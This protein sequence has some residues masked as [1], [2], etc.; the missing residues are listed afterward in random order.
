[1]PRRVVPVAVL[2]AI[3]VAL[4]GIVPTTS[5][6]C[7]GATRTSVHGVWTYAQ[8]PD[9]CTGAY[10]DRRGVTMWSL[11]HDGRRFIASG[12]T[13]GAITDVA[14]PAAF[15]SVDGRAWT[16]RLLPFDA[17]LFDAPDT[18]L[19]TSGGTTVLVGS[20]IAASTT[21]GTDWRTGVGPEAGS[22]VVGAAGRIGRWIAVGH[23]V[24]ALGA[25]MW[26]STNGFEWR[27]VRRQP[28]F[29]TFCPAAIAANGSTF[30]AVGSG[31]EADHGVILIS[32]DGVTW[33]RRTLPTARDTL[34]RT[35]VSTAD[36][37]L[38]GGDDQS[39][40][41]RRGMAI[42]HSRDGLN[43]RRVAFF[44]ALSGGERLVA[45][46]PTSAGVLAIAERG[47]ITDGVAPTSFYSP[48]GTSGWRRNGSLPNPGYGSEDGDRV[49][50]AAAS[51]RRAVAVG[52]FNDPDPGYQTSG[53]VTWIGDVRR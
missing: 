27:A 43:W 42:W 30:V 5:A 20:R 46:V 8:D 2:G 29:S 44:S 16:E 9:L 26:A 13:A 36:G 6:T 7:S 19:A 32:R 22:L 38:A 48:S 25:S 31:C 4:F 11:V 23:H 3:L 28:T 41:G 40:T 45:I 37:F 18:S 50:A 53:G 24:D 14:V 47:E 34:L 52:W 35:V 12:T 17:D 51:G 10:H 15:S 1:M 39:A 33:T 21:N 49:N